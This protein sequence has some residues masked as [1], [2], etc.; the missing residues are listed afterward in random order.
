MAK[1]YSPDALLALGQK[2]GAGALAKDKAK[3]LKSEGK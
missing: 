2:R 1:K 3:R